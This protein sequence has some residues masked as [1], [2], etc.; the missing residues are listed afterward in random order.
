MLI[1]L[2]TRLMVGLNPPILRLRRRDSR[3]QLVL[4]A[5]PN[6]LIFYSENET[7]IKESEKKQLQGYITT[8]KGTENFLSWTIF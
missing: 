8:F 7:S 3:N 4:T 2:Q 5:T 6:K 1:R